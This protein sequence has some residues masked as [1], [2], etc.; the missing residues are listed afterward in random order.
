MLVAR[1]EGSLHDVAARAEDIGSPEVLV[2]PGDVANPED[3]QRFVQAAVEHFG[4][5]KL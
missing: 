1:R 2:V 3:C 5:C 4:Q